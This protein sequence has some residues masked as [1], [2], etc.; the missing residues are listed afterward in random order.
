[1]S[2]LRDGDGVAGVGSAGSDGRLG[3][4]LVR[5][6]ASSEPVSPFIAVTTPVTVPTTVTT[7]AA[8]TMARRLAVRLRSA[9]RAARRWA[10]K[11]DTWCSPLLPD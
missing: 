6:R 10:R 3:E 11:P 7:A 5:G 1:M 9:R 8:T 4:R 2:E